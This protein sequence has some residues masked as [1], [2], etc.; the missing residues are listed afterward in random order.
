MVRPSISQSF[1]AI[2]IGQGLVASDGPAAAESGG[3]SAAKGASRNP[4][5]SGGPRL[6]AAAL[7]IESKKQEADQAARR[8]AAQKAAAR[9]GGQAGRVFER[10]LA[11]ADEKKFN[12]MYLFGRYDKDGSGEL[13]PQEFNAALR[14]L[15]VLLRPSELEAI[16]AELDTDGDGD[17]ATS[18]FYTRMRQAQKDRFVSAAAAPPAAAES[19]SAAEQRLAQKRRDRL[20]GDPSRAATSLG[21]TTGLP[22]YASRHRCVVSWDP[23]NN[24]KIEVPIHG[25]WKQQG[26]PAPYD[27]G[28]RLRRPRPKSVEPEPPAPAFVFEAGNT[29][30][31]V[32]PELSAGFGGGGDSGSGSLGGLQQAS[33]RRPSRVPPLALSGSPERR[34]RAVTVEPVLSQEKIARRQVEQAKA[35]RRQMAQQQGRSRGVRGSIA[36]SFEPVALGVYQS[37]DLDARLEEHRGSKDFGPDVPDLDVGQVKAL[38]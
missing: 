26:R 8:Q 13:D 25:K 10:I 38:R 20:R 19:G 2:Q 17:A 7:E 30:P 6:S 15:R 28:G 37:S 3:L 16:M 14:E 27:P 21:H 4:Q 22:E 35:A 5:Q 31:L 29:Q 11:A 9:R 34:R 1:Q 18:E 24:M 33:G 12:L 36:K 32:R 23:H